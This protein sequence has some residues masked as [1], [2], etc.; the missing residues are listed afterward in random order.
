MRKGVVG[1]KNERGIKILSG[2]GV[3]IGSKV[4]THEIKVL[5][6][7]FSD[8]RVFGNFDVKT[9]QFIFDLFDKGKH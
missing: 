6:K 7:Q 4:Y 9:G 8:Y 1:P 2:N 5:N 3:K